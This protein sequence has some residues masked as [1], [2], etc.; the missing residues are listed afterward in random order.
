MEP[1]EP[2][3]SEGIRGPPDTSLRRRAAWCVYLRAAAAFQARFGGLRDLEKREKPFKGFGLRRGS[4]DAAL[5]DANRKHLHHEGSI[6]ID[7]EPLNKR[8]SSRN[9]DALPLV[10]VRSH[11]PILPGAMKQQRAA[12]PLPATW[13][14]RAS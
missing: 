2:E 12:W 9:G 14:R 6:V 4:S 7:L 8:G 5:F 1:P 3:L 11:L 10:G 13:L